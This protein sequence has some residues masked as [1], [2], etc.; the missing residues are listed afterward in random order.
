MLQWLYLKSH[1]K[2]DGL[3]LVTDSA[4]VSLACLHLTAHFLFCS[5][6]IV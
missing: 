1:Y 2:K 3:G 4:V 5:V 6:L